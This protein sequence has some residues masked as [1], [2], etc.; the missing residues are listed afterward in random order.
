M[1]NQ[2]APEDQAR[3][4]KRIAEL[5][6]QELSASTIAKLVGVSTRTV[7]RARGRAGVAKPFSG[8][9][10]MTADEQRR[11]AALLDDGASYGEVARTLGRSPDT[12]MKHFPGRSVWR[13]GS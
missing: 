6:A 1:T 5:T 12:I 2:L 4:D 7:V 9:N 8:A 10:R 11:A 3:R 13:P